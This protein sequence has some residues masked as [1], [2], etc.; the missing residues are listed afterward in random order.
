MLAVVGAGT[1]RVGPAPAALSAAPPRVAAA[2]SVGS[3]SRSAASSHAAP[4]ASAPTPATDDV[5]VDARSGRRGSSVLED[6]NDPLQVAGRSVGDT[7][8][9]HQA[10]R[11]Y[12]GN[13]SAFHN[14]PLCGLGFALLV[15]SPFS[16]LKPNTGGASQ[17]DARLQDFSIR[18]TRRSCGVSFRPIVLVRPGRKFDLLSAGARALERS[19][20]SFRRRAFLS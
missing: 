20:H 8:S 15:A 3:P 9:G 13:Q 6:G 16:R 2:P 12:C 10:D 19:A 17:R 5:L 7:K 18:A 4:S 1:P 14:F 11:Q